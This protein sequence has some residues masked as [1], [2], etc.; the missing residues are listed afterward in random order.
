[1]RWPAARGIAGADRGGWIGP[2]PAGPPDVGTARAPSRHV[3]DRHQPQA[4]GGSCLPKAVVRASSVVRP[5][6]AR[7][8]RPPRASER[9]R[10]PA[11]IARTFARRV[12]VES[13]AGPR[14]IA[15]RPRPSCFGQPNGGIGTDGARSSSTPASLRSRRL[16]TGGRRRLDAESA[17]ARPAIIARAELGRTRRRPGMHPRAPRPGGRVMLPNPPAPGAT[18]CPDRI[19]G[20]R[21][22]RRA[23]IDGHRRRVHPFAGGRARRDDPDRLGIRSAY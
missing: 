10:F 6:R 17:A 2:R 4:G 20:R 14:G 11:A 13:A 8:V 12:L 23:P 15:T 9:S 18:G 19:D 21:R 5:T 7:C 22:P 1:M 16:G 3:V